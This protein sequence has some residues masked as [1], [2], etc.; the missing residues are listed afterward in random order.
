MDRIQIGEQLFFQRSDGRVHPVVCTGKNP[1]LDSV[2]G[3]W[4]EGAVVKG[5]EVPISMLIGINRHIFAENQPPT[6]SLIPK[7]RDVSPSGGRQ[8][9]QRKP[10]GGTGTANP[11]AER[12]RAMDFRSKLP[13]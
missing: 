9:S 2:T 8:D 10:S 3:E 4:T 7:P 5:K 1:E 6:G 11:Y 13:T 12:M